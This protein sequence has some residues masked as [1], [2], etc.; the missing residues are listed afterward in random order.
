MQSYS[1]NN[2]IS[3]QAENDESKG[4]AHYVGRTPELNSL[5]LSGSVLSCQQPT[6][7]MTNVHTDDRPQNICPSTVAWPKVEML[8]KAQLLLHSWQILIWKCN[9]P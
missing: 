8:F 5:H 4:Q 7:S 2:L 1:I 3:K 9:K 6:W